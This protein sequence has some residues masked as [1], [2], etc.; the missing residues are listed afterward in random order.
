MAC[1][2]ARKRVF[3]IL[4]MHPQMSSWQPSTDVEILQRLRYKL[5]KPSTIRNSYLVL[6]DRLIAFCLQSQVQ[7]F[8]PH[9]C[10]ILFSVELYVADIKIHQ[11]NIAILLQSLVRTFSIV[12]VPHLRASVKRSETFSDLMFDH[13]FQRFWS[14]G[15]PKSFARSTKQRR[16]TWVPCKIL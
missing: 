4:G 10:N 13:N 1:A 2:R 15:T 9:A 16:G 11:K 14:R 3:G 7:K 6:T 5:L 8:W 12:R